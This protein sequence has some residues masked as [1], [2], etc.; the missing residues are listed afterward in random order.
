MAEL[1]HINIYLEVFMISSYLA[2]PRQVHVEQV[3]HIFSYLKKYHNTEI[4]FDPSDSVID[5]SLFS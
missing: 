5:E 1:G 2:L 4:V 3:L